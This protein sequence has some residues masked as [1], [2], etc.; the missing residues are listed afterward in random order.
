MV[1]ANHIANPSLKIFLSC[2]G[3][4]L[5]YPF[6]G[7]NGRKRAEMCIRDSLFYYEDLS[8]REISEILG[9]GENTIKSQLSRART[10]LKEKLKGEYDYV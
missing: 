5:F 10:L 6:I 3:C 8:I 9:I 7:S 4:G 2:N 1:G